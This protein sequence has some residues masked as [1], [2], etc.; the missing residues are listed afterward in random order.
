MAVVSL[1]WSRSSPRLSRFSVTGKPPN[2]FRT[3]SIATVVWGTCR[4]LSKKEVSDCQR[5]TNSSI[6]RNLSAV[7]D[8]NELGTFHFLKLFFVQSTARPRAQT[9]YPASPPP[10]SPTHPPPAPS[11]IPSPQ[12]SVAAGGRLVKRRRRQP[13]QR[14]QCQ[15]IRGTRGTTIWCKMS[16]ESQL[17]HEPH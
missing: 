13:I 8:E 2:S 11:L 5:M 16:Q 6:A 3:L 10:S 12:P 14:D 17:E 9:A 15:V 7:K 1:G 4:K